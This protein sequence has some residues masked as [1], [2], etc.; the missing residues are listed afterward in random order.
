MLFANNI[1]CC[2]NRYS[3]QYVTF[4]L[5]YFRNLRSSHCG[6]FETNPTSIH[7]A[8]GLIPGF[9]QWVGIWHC[10]E[11]WCRSQTWLRSHVVLAVA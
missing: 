5:I 7:E 10:L 2:Y 4:S 9:T 6:A 1:L 3:D 8:V 11:L